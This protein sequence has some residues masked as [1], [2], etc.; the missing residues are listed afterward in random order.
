MKLEM[1]AMFGILP[2]S[3]TVSHGLLIWIVVAP[4]ARPLSVL[5]NVSVRIAPLPVL[6]KIGV[7]AKVSVLPMIRSALLTTSVVPAA[8]VTPAPPSGLPVKPTPPWLGELLAP[9]TI[10]PPWTARPPANSFAPESW[11]RPA[12]VLTI[13]TFT[14]VRTEVMLRVGRMSV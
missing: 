7:P 1:L 4:V 3:A 8:I 10:P 9:R 14:P 5:F 12:P 13:A 2:S 11:S 6:S